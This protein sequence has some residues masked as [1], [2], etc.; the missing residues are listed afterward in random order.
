MS[1]NIWAILVKCQ[2]GLSSKGHKLGEISQELMK[3][4]CFEISNTVGKCFLKFTVLRVIE[5]VYKIISAVHFVTYFAIFF[6]K[7]KKLAS[8]SR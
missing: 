8:K 7:I 5:I 3:I 1:L 2:L 4:E 6:Q